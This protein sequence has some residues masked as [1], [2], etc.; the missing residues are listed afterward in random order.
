[1]SILQNLYYGACDKN[2]TFDIYIKY[3]KINNGGDIM[4]KK[5]LTIRE[6]GE[7]LRVSVNTVT[8]WVHL[9]KIPA[10]RYGRQWRIPYE[11]VSEWLEKGE[12]N[13]NEVWNDEERPKKGRFSLQG[14]IEGGG[15]ITEQEIDEV[16]EE[17]NRI[18][19]EE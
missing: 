8:R 17:F 13:P 15:P 14:I 16:I 12:G 1:M 19:S 7:E 10:K 2:N 3:G 18:G 11:A 4:E 5:Y 6:V 9:K